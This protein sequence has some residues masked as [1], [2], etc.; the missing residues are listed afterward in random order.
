MVIDET[1]AAARRLFRERAE[2]TRTEA[3]IE[4]AIAQIEEQ[5]KFLMAQ[6][7]GQGTHDASGV[8]QDRAISQKL[9]GLRER[10]EKLQE[11]LEFLE[12][13]APKRPGRGA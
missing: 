5:E 6:L 3:M 11:E 8:T 9:H 10:R 7:S 2:G 4:S 12:D 1:S 13:H